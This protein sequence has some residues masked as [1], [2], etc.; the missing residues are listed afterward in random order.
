M[1]TDFNERTWLIWLGKVR[2]IVITFLLGIELAVSVLTPTN[3]PTR[4]FV[5]VILLW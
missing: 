4:L 2:I 3:L 5:S 1:R